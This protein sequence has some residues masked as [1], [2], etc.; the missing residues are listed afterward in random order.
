MR[1]SN[2]TVVIPARSGSK[3]IPNKNLQIIEGRS[4]IQITLDFAA[5]L[6][7]RE[8]ILSSDSEKF[9]EQSNGYPNV[10]RHL[11][12]RKMSD[13]SVSAR[14]VVSSLF[15]EG[16]IS[17]SCAV[18]LQPTSPFRLKETLV[19]A[20]ELA[21]ESKK[22]VYSVSEY[23][24]GHPDWSMAHAGD[25]SIQLPDGFNVNSQSQ[26]LVPRYYLNGNFFVYHKS[27]ISNNKFSAESSIGFICGDD[28]EAMDVDSHFDLLVAR[29]IAKDFFRE[30][31]EGKNPL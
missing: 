20:I 7:A 14:S 30:S 17:T 23:K 6:G 1:S 12:Q 27:L 18:L 26:D 19:R 25:G 21:L 9:L 3:R 2:F 13:D 4:L 8:I 15:R 29:R 31:A 16:C 24:K 11:R 22:N 28:F 5:Q 10:K